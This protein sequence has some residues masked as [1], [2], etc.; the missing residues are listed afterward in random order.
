MIRKI[1]N[2]LSLKENKRRYLNLKGIASRRYAYKGPDAIQIDLTNRCNSQCLICWDHSPFVKNNIDTKAEDLD[3][4]IAKNLINDSAKL[5]T[6]EIIFSGGGEP[7]S[8]S[9]VW[10]MLE[11]TQRAGL[12][13]RINTNLTLL[14][15]K[16]IKRLLSF[17][18][19]TSLT[20]SIWGGDMLLYTKLHNR[21][22]DSFFKLKNNLKFLNITKS[23][24]LYTRVCAIIN[25]MNYPGIK[26]LVNLAA[27][28]GCSTVEFRVPDVIPGVTDLFLLDKSQLAFVKRDFINIV[29]DQNSRNCDVKIINKDIFLRRILSNKACYG[30]YDSFIDKVPCYAGWLFLR[31]RANGDFNSCL[32]S[33]RIPI[34]N[35]YKEDVFSVWNNSLQEE[36]RDQ[37]LRTPKDRRYF[38]NVGNGNDGA[39]GCRRICDNILLNEH[40]R[41]IARYLFWI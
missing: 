30:E 1:L 8:Y 38:R 9:K 6:R 5:G 41:K 23:P 37:A 12:F 20:I 2:K 14:T 26:D 28:T 3:F 13:F 40:W 11:F 4:S 33:H 34:G 21:D 17:D 25:N 15:K 10:E 31:L 36:F 22:A 35:I 18:K 27:E 7:F 39:V 19:L 29:K 32:K 16:D 24:K